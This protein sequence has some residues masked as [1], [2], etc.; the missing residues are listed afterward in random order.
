MALLFIH[1]LFFTDETADNFPDSPDATLPAVQHCNNLDNLVCAV[2]SS[3]NMCSSD[4]GKNNCC[5]SCQTTNGTTGNS[6]MNS[7]TN[8]DDIVHC[9]QIKVAN[10][11]GDDTL[12]QICCKACS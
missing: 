5:A 7:C 2:I 3:N 10:M 1:N 12:F 9:E 11:C 6:S 8:T 4:F